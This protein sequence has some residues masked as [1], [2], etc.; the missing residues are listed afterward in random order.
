MAPPTVLDTAR[1]RPCSPPP[2]GGAPPRP[3]SPEVAVRGGADRYADIV[4]RDL[5]PG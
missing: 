4:L 5:R 1:F 3:D 2:T